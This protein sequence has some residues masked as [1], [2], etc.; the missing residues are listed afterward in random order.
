[1]PM[2]DCP[3]RDDNSYLFDLDDSHGR[4]GV[5]SIFSSPSYYIIGAALIKFIIMS[6]CKCL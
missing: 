6:L 1:M 2:D 4:I 5:D 3:I